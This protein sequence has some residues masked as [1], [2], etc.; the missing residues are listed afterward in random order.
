MY[1]LVI[2]NKNYSSW[3]LRPWVLM[4]V[5]NIS[6]REISLNIYTPEGKQQLQQYSETAKVP[7]L[8]HQDITIWDS[9]AI[10]EYLAEQHPDKNLW[11]STTAARA[12]ARAVVS[13]MHSGFTGV[14]NALPMNCRRNITLT[15][16][17]P[18]SQRDI[19]RI[20]H[21]WRDCRT[22]F[23]GEGNFLFGQFSIAD[24]FYA[25]IVIRFHGYGISLGNIERDYMESM[26]ALPAMRQ[27]INAGRQE[28]TYVAQYDDIY[29]E[30]DVL[31]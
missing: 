3:S 2:G 15:T 17:D 24:A 9:L 16:I 6:F 21:I 22:R 10:A 14:R 29:S 7:V 28:S 31:G 8:I 18:A 30:L 4:Q 23:G 20:S 25:P 13:E 27:W 5:A 1:Q 19:E 11:P 12:Q 26:L